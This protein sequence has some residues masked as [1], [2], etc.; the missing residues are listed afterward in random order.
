MFRSILRA[1][2]LALAVLAGPTGPAPALA[3]A[4]TITEADPVAVVTVP[5][6]WSSKKIPRGIQIKTP[7]DE[8]FMW[9]ELVAPNE[10]DAVQKEHDEYFAKQG[11]TVSG[12]ADT[13][14]I[15]V[16][17]RPW[18]ISEIKGKYK[19]EDTIIRY[20]VI[21]PK[22]ASS[23]L[24]VLSYWASPEGDKEHGDATTKMLESIGFK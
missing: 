19:D 17:G 5:D 12:Q 6:A 4:F 22:L 24:I 8:I 2:A 18:V 13:A 7:D 16:G 10:L 1:S 20:V 9:F 14:S 21:N 11:V 23:K 15:E 3:E